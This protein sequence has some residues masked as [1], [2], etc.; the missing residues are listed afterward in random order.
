[1]YATSLIYLVILIVVFDHVTPI[2]VVPRHQ[3]VY[4]LVGH[5]DELN[6]GHLLNE[7]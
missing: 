1:M 7:Q 6:L 2:D 5:H 4:F 3:Y